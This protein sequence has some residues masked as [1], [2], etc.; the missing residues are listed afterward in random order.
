MFLDVP[1]KI[2]DPVVLELPLQWGRELISRGT[3]VVV[4]CQAGLL[5]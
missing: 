5:L 3:H 1:Q 2:K 4:C